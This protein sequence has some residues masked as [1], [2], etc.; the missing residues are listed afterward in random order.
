[1]KSSSR[2]PTL[3]TSI[4]LLAVTL[5]PITAQSVVGDSINPYRVVM[6]S[7]LHGISLLDN[8]DT[9]LSGYSYKGAGYHFSHETLRKAHCGSYNWKYQT[10][11]D[12]TIGYATLHNSTQLMAMG[13]RRWSGYHPVNIGN[14][15]QL[16]AGVQ[17]QAEGGALYIPSNGN[18]PVSVKLRTAMAASGM[19]IYKFNIS[20]KQYKARYQ[21]EI[22]LAGVMFSPEFGQS[23]YEI[24]GLGHTDGTVKFANFINCPS[25]RHIA[26]LDIPIGDSTLRVAYI[27]DLYQSKVNSLRTH[28][29]SHTIAIGFAK[30]IYKVKRNDPIEAYTPF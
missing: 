15:L 4:L 24:F 28:L 8:L 27:A 20:N 1:M 23:Y 22:P 2:I 9:Y 13:A 3:I 21:L 11:T 6:R 12:F 14:N 25:W 26:S 17:I 5:S 10:Q 29:Y 18:N 16:L 19:A 30:T 7:S